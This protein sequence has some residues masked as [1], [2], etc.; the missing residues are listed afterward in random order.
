[1]RGRGGVG[2]RATCG[3]RGPAVGVLV[4]VG[5]VGVA[6]TGAAGAGVA[7]WTRGRRDRVALVRTCRS[8]FSASRRSGARYFYHFALAWVFFIGI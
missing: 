2:R 3:G 7:R 8:Q 5:V 1:V 4:V 6:D